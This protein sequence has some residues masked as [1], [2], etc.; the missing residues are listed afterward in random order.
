MPIVFVIRLVNS[1]DTDA[2]FISVVASFGANPEL[3][4]F[5]KSSGNCVV[6]TA[7]TGTS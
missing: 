5:T 1:E 7:I 4:K 3:A 6:I 2:D